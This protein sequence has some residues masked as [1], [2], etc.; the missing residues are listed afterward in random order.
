RAG[1][2]RRGTR[3]QAGLPA[4]RGL[5]R[6]GGRG[7]ARRAPR[8]RLPR[9]GAARDRARGGVLGG[10]PGNHGGCGERS[11]GARRQPR[12]QMVAR[13]SL[14]RRP[15]PGAHPARR[16]SSVV[17][18]L[19]ALAPRLVRLAHHDYSDRLLGL[20]AVAPC[21]LLVGLA[22]C[23]TVDGSLARD[24]SGRLT[25]T[26]FPGRHATTSGETRRFSSPHVTLESLEGS[27]QAEAVARVRFDDAARLSSAAAF[28]GLTVT[29][30]C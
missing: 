20:R 6:R 16:T 29:R 17:A 5:D 4:A 22:G 2:V 21:A 10:R 27:G 23:F 18:A 1:R 13:S 26:Y 28:H 30:E 19:A 25:L 8:P 11:G 14:L 24:G 7:A 12:C 15:T 3:A 9:R